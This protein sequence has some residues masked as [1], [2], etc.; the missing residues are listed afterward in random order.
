[1]IIL[2]STN[3]PKCKV[4]KKKLEQKNIP[5]IENNNIE[6]MKEKGIYEVPVLEKDEILF[7]FT[8][9]INKINQNEFN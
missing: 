2:Y 4:L 1:M 8:E 3:C 6:E 5:F 9:A 7:N